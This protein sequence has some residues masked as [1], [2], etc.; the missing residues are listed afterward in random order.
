MV[1]TNQNSIINTYIKNRKKSKHNNR[2]SYQGTREES[3]RL[4]QEHKRATKT[5][6]NNLHNDNKYIPINNYFK[7]K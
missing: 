5:T 4:T 3:K 1:I 7:C 2:D 6:Q